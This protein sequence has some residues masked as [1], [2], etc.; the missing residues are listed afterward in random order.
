MKKVFV[1]IG[2]NNTRINDVRKIKSKAAELFG[3]STVL[4]KT[5]PDDGD[6]TA[7][8]Y[9]I[10][11]KLDGDVSDMSA[12]LNF[13]RNHELEII[14]V[15]PFSDTGIMLGAQLCHELS[16]PGPDMEKC[17]GA[18]DKY[19]FRQLEQNCTNTPHSYRVVNSTVVTTFSAFEEVCKKFE[20]RCFLKPLR[21]GNSRGCIEITVDSN[22]QSCWEEVSPYLKGGI[23]VE[24]LIEGEREFSWDHVAGYNWITEKKTTPNQY[25]AEYQ[26]IVPARLS[27][28]TSAVIAAGGAHI[29]AL[30][31]SNGGACHNE[32]FLLKDGHSVSGVEPNLRPAG[33]RIWDLA[34]LAFEQFD[35]WANWLRWSTGGSLITS[36]E[37]NFK[38]YAG[39][40]FI[41][42]P[43]DGTFREPSGYEEGLRRSLDTSVE[44]CELFWTKK[45]GQSVRQTARDGSDYVGYII[46]RCSSYEKLEIA[47]ESADRFMAAVLHE[48]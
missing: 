25:R 1:V 6:R 15:L 24:A 19:R 38:A 46:M 45:Q 48:A 7:V 26:E 11:V 4:C 9:V 30:T 13:A 16:L 36:H 14:G 22:L 32:I 37:L 39:I 34:A 23:V 17:Q 41:E 31:G 40:R 12:V 29:A 27:A 3:A 33:G 44:L 43:Y 28:D 20:Y 35:P 5:S 8:D 10:D 42:S 21:E 18:L 47:L 2:Y